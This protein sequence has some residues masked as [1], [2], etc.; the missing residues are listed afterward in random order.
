MT[1]VHHATAYIYTETKGKITPKIQQ[2]LCLV[3]LEDKDVL[4]IAGSGSGKTLIV[5]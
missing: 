1:G 4:Y 3:D 5:A 2:L